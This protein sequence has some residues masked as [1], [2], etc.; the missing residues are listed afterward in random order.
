[1]P[2]IIRRLPF[3]D[4]KQLLATATGTIPVYRN[5]IVL[6]INVAEPGA[7]EPGPESPKFPALFDPGTN[8]NFLI[9]EEHFWSWANLECSS[10]VK[11]D[12][13]FVNQQSR[14]VYE[15]NIWVFPNIPGT[16]EN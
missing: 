15:A 2:G 11:L 4:Q 16:V 5:Q 14:P 6:W 8:H 9:Q 7:P 1:M 12:S 13:I 10:L 3:I